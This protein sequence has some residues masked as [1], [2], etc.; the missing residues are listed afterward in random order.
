[1]TSF[2]SEA[3]IEEKLI[4]Q[5][6]E[7][8]SQWTFRDDIRSFDDLW[9][10]FRR[11][12][13]QNNKE[14]F[15]AHPLTDNE[16]LQVQNQLRFTSFYDA[17]V[18][19]IGE[20][21]VV[22]VMIQREDASLG[23]VY[24]VVFKRAD[25][26]GGSS[27]YEVVHQIRFLRKE[28]MNRDRRGD[29]TLLINGLPMI[30][31]ELKNRSHPY[32]DGFRQI[33]QYLKENAF[34]DIFST[35]QMFVVSNAAD[36][37][38]IATASESELNEKFLSTWLD[39][40]NRPVTDYLSF[41][42]AVLSIPEAHQMV[43]QYTVLDSERKALI[44]LRPYQIHAIRA[45][46]RAVNPNTDGGTQSGYIW[47]TTGSGKTLTSYK[48][49]RYLS[50]IPSI[51]KVVF[52]VD[53]RDLDNQTT[54]A[55]QAYA[56]YDTIDVSETD[57]SRDLVKKL[58]S[59][60]GD[61]L[62][63]TIQKLQNVMKRYPK[64]SKPYEKLHALRPVFVVDECHRAVSAEAQRELNRYFTS[65]LWYGFTGTPIFSEDAKNTAG[66]LPATTEE[67]YGK[68][69]HAYTIKEA[70]HD[71]AVLGFQVEYQNTFDME[72]LAAEN[73]ISIQGDDAG[74]ERALIKGKV[75][76]KVYEDEQHMLQVINFIINRS[77]GKLGLDRGR[78]KTYGAILTTS[79]IK[80]A[81]RY[82][83]L[84]RAVKDRKIDG[85]FVHD[86][87]RRQLSDFPKV[88][89]TYSVGENKE[90]DTFN[91]DRMKEAMTDYNTM[92][93][94]QFTLEQLDAYN[95]NVNDR[96]ARK[97]RKYQVRDEQ[98]DI[99]IVVDRLL[100]GFDAPS[101][102][103]LFIDRQPMKSYGI[104]QAFSRTNRLFDK[105][106]RFGQ[107]VTFQV[108]ALFKEAVDAAMTLYSSGG[109]SYVQ[110][111]TWA[112]AEDRFVEA[113][114]RIRRLA[115]TPEAVDT[116]SRK[117]KLSFLKAYREF[118][119]AYADL[120][121]YS[122]YQEKDLARDYGI[123]EETIE[124]YNG[125]FNNVK[126]ELKG[127]DNGDDPEVNLAINYDLRCCHR[128]QIDEDYILKLMEA[129]RGDESALILEDSDR[130][131]Q[132]FAEINAE[133]TRFRKTNP[134]RAAILEG[135]WQEYQERPVDFVN[136]NFAD[137][138]NE[139]VDKE[140]MR[141]I[142]DFAEE[143]CV[144]PEVL[145][146]YV[147][148]FDITKDPDDKQDNQDALREASHV[149]EYRKKNPGVSGLKYWPNLKMALWK[150]YEE[151]I[152]KLQERV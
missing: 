126:E 152:Q 52:V 110:A 48:A 120:Q 66:D 10:N 108:P 127:R 45:I 122:D 25:I 57:N 24:P 109:G 145:D 63:T 18:W 94:T 111:P 7:G 14:I 90:G 60:K 21:G 44:L 81:Q 121:V 132:L 42:K 17:A 103:T 68:R 150:L 55:F 53:R 13:V 36:T 147:E 59:D 101:L 15:D 1:M 133:I 51:K 82:Y 79:S 144:E 125:K 29:V 104:I 146:Y 69:L 35:L 16:F 148:T 116:M 67:Q 11:I 28:A 96:L 62:V 105:Q 142:D 92:F 61:V 135:I 3:S 23:R 4:R 151:K 47:H 6:T 40:A 114:K 149:K 141:L 115:P 138:L 117:E 9:D 33:K 58:Q 2:E 143:W 88:A 71:E 50:Q 129:A 80:Q 93:G 5:L 39:E 95:S 86:A 46:R 64:G 124:A 100:T 130:N 56:A 37:R 30:H 74:V 91:Q 54:G 41:A 112:E 140:R 78:G 32:M 22:R 118:D 89:I 77:A 27:V 136:R 8:K 107:I 20:N 123:D 113:L 83:Q 97:K 75:I 99:V 72:T 76:P 106:K 131:R 137:V 12:L 70:L 84:F 43:S 31:I 49:A 102:S 73:G 85:I 134:V 119:N 87:T 34:Q 26:A 139:R 38:Y 19:L 65:P 128:D 98:L